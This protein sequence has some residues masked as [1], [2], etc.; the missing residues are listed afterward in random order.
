G[1]G[2]KMFRRDHFMIAV[3][4]E[5]DDAG[6]SAVARSAGRDIDVAIVADGEMAGSAQPFC[7][8][9][10]VEA[11]RQ[12]KVVGLSG[13]SRTGQAGKRQRSS[14]DLHDVLPGSGRESWRGNA[15]IYRNLRVYA[16][17]FLRA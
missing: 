9:G 14:S 4:P 11:R 3:Q 15:G 5:R 13:K 2:A 8:H 17:D 1:D 7:D 6:R 10:G 16:L 12:D